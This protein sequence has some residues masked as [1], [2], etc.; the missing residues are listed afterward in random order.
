MCLGSAVT[1]TSTPVGTSTRQAGSFYL[2]CFWQAMRCLWFLYMSGI[3]NH[4]DLHSSR[5]VFLASQF[6][7]TVLFLTGSETSVVPRCIWDPV[8]HIRPPQY[9]LLPNQLVHTVSIVFE[10]RWNVSGQYTCLGSSFTQTST[11]AGTSTW[12]GSSFWLYCF[13]QAVRC[14]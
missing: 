8:S 13:W 14:L 10:R 9:K 2:Y 11:L 1:G 5:N 12:P 4:T 3:P 6:I 7:L